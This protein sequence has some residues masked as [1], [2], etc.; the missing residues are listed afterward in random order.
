MTYF[1]C[2]GC[3]KRYE[4]TQKRPERCPTCSAPIRIFFSFPDDGTCFI[5]RKKTALR[6]GCCYDC[7]K[8]TDG[9][10]LG[11]GFHEIWSTKKPALR[12]V[13]HE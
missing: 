8:D 13:V 5:C 1:F 12:I 7:A 4:T 11:N 10:N 6:M 3:K 2:L 9:R